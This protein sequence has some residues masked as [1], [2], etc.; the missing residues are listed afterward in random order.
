[1]LQGLE[2]GLNLR[3][4]GLLVLARV[5]LQHTMLCRVRISAAVVTGTLTRL[6]AYFSS[7]GRHSFWKVAHLQTILSSKYC[8]HSIVS[9]SI[10]GSPP[11]DGLLL[12]VEV[13][14]LQQPGD[15]H[16]LT[17]RVS[18]VLTLRRF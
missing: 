6:P 16:I 10:D 3:C 1:M 15:H 12:V 18:S 7:T 14:P 2:C 8:H 11:A 5:H 17:Y 4:D 9:M 13:A